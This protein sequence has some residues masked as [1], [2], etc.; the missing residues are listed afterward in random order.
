MA[1]DFQSRG[2]G[3]TG[4]RDQVRGFSGCL[5]DTSLAVMPVSVISVV[6]EPTF[7]EIDF[8]YLL[9]RARTAGCAERT[10]PLG[11][12]SRFFQSGAQGTNGAPKRSH[13]W[14]KRYPMGVTSC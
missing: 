11:S 5:S 13:E 14:T 2:T 7:I 1:E 8:Y 12:R 9:G 10:D 3:P 4:L 6:A